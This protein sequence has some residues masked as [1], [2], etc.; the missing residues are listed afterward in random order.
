M[1]SRDSFY[2]TWSRRIDWPTMAAMATLV[3]IGLVAV[4]SAV[5]PSGA[6]MR[7]MLKQLAATVLGVVAVFVLS[8]LNYQI[9]RAYPSVIYGLTIFALTA[10]LVIGR[11]IHGAK[12]WIVFGP[13]SI[14]PVEIARI[15]FIVA[16]A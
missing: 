3:V 13:L 4:F 16:I 15:G 14:E 6:S 7:Y 2:G 8:S 10:V 11:R 1:I 12:S 9:F 5:N